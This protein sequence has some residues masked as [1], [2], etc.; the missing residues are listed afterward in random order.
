MKDRYDIFPVGVIKK[1]S[2]TVR[3]E[4]FKEYR[5]ALLRLD[6][7]SHI[8]VCYWFHE[9]DTLKKRKTLQVHPRKNKKNPLSGVFATHSPLR[10]NL[11]AISICKILSIKDTTIFIEKIDAFDGSPVIDI[12]C[13]IPSRTLTSDIRLPDW[14]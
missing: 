6:D 2:E 8:T 12:K 5:D 14:V 7:F 13:F 10:P 9:N 4:I 1:D 3:I 11:I